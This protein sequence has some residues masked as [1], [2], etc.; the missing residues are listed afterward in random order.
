[1]LR[2][3]CQRAAGI[4]RGWWLVS[5]AMALQA[6]L[7]GLFFQAYGAYAAYWMAEFGWSR[8]TISLAY[9]LHRTESGLLGPLHGWLLQ[10]VSPRRVIVAGVVLL[11]VG[12]M[13]LSTVQNFVQFIAVFLVMAVGASLCGLL[14]LMTVLVN[15]FER[16]RA[17]ALSLM[18]TGMSIGGLAVPLVALGLVA[19]G[20]RPMAF[21]SGIVVIVVGLP[22]ARLMRRD[23]EQV[24]LRPDGAGPV[25]GGD[26]GVRARR[27]PAFTVRQALRTWAFWSMSIA[28]A[29]AVAVVAAVSVHFVI[30]ANEAQGLSITAAASILALMTGV[31]IVGQLVGGVLGDRVDKRV[32]TTA[33]ML[34]HALAM[35]L[36][37]LAA[38]PLAVIVAAVVH[39]VSWG[40]RGPLMGALRADYFGRDSFAAVMGS[41]SL[42]VMLGSVGGPLLVGIVTD[43]TGTYTPAFLAL[44]A[45]ALVGSVGFATLRR[46]EPAPAA[47]TRARR[48]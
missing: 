3:L 31:S 15:W 38:T 7:A 20:W 22:I 18:Q 37:A 23:P 42:I 40:L 48:S 1:M 4:Y 28:H 25:D 34:G 30:Y 27:G 29:A 36:L 44:A 13:V 11:G 26:G 46:P 19:F 16:R 32:L 47:S 43:L 24:G 14:S 35:V 33:G 21:A 5:G 17:T 8:T 9:S 12:F 45:L 39:G 2:G 6:V 41:S 10:R